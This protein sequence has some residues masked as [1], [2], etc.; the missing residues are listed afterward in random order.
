MINSNHRAESESFPGRVVIAV[1]TYRRTDGLARTVGALLAACRDH[2]LASVL[3]IDNNPGADARSAVWAMAVRE[4]PGRVLYAHEPRPGIAAARNRAILEAADA[5]LLVFVDDDERPT[6]GWLGNLLRL[7]AERRPA[8]IAGPVVSEFARQPEPWI[9]GGRFFNRRRMPTGTAID[10]AATNNLLIDLTQLRAL[11][12]AFADEFGLTGGSDTLFTRQIVRRGGTILWCDEAVVIDQVPAGRLTRHWVLQK[13]FRQGNIAPRVGM[14]LV[15]TALGRVRVR[16]LAVV[17][18]AAR[19][20]AG[21]AAIL[22]GAVAPN[23]GRRARGTRRAVRGAGML[24]GACGYTY[25]E[26]SRKRDAAPRLGSYRPA[27][28]GGS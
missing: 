1:L 15:D 20:A 13:A 4:P 23:I 7:H 16:L 10:C 14:A 22:L 27:R 8:A 18:G 25:V 3:V 5:P 28:A 6:P 21:A 9:V 12:V 17:G 2:P 11:G 19:M 26:Y 24:L